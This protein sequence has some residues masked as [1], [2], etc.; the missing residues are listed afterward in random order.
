MVYY[1]IYT[2]TVTFR[3]VCVSLF[4][5]GTADYSTTSGECC[6]KAKQRETTCTIELVVD[7]VSEREEVLRI[8]LAPKPGQC[9]CE[10]PGSTTDITIKETGN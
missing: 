10:A 3:S 8:K 1:Y 7:S 2:Y 6:F 4:C 9:V 5:I